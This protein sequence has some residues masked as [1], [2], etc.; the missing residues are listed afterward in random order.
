MMYFKKEFMR[1]FVVALAGIHSTSSHAASMESTNDWRTLQDGR[2]EAASTNSQGF[3]LHIG[4]LEG[5][6]WLGITSNSDFALHGYQ[7][8]R[9]KLAGIDEIELGFQDDGSSLRTPVTPV[10]LSQL[11]RSDR[12]QITVGGSRTGFALPNFESL[13]PE[14]AA[15]ANVSSNVKAVERKVRGA[16]TWEFVEGMPEGACAVRA[17][18]SEIDTLLMLNDAGELILAGGR[19][20]WSIPPAV[21]TV[22]IGVDSQP[23]RQFKASTLNNLLLIKIADPEAIQRLRVGNRMV[24]NLPVGKLHA[25]IKGLGI[26]MDAIR[27]CKSR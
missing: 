18:G 17:R 20:D 10:L 9:I 21:G 4:A 8:G 25:N 14:L 3:T 19:Q 23:E 24:W 16:E 12:V 11:K 7:P 13:I 26:A 5:Q 22:D 27:Q 15:C 2:C 6:Y 1:L